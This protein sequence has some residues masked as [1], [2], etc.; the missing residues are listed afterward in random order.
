MRY[1]KF[2][3]LALGR[4]KELERQEKAIKYSDDLASFIFNPKREVKHSVR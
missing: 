4:K 2:D 3:R 1:N